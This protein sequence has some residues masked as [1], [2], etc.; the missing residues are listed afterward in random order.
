MYT[1]TKHSDELCHYGVLGMR[2]GVRR[3]QN[4]DGT[5]IGTGGEPVTNQSKKAGSSVAL[6][7][8]GKAKGNARL[9]ATAASPATKDKIKNLTEPSVKQGKGKD[10]ISPAEKI[11]RDTKKGVDASKSI[12]S[13]AEKRANKRNKDAASEQQMKKAKNMSDKELRDSINR[14]KMEREYT[15]LTTKEVESGWTKARE[16]LEVVGDVVEI[17]GA[18]LGIYLMLKKA[19]IIHSDITFEEFENTVDDD[20]IMHFVDMGNEEVEEYLEHHGVLGMK[21]GVRRYQNYD[22]TRIGAGSGSGGGGGGSSASKSFRGSVATGQGGKAVGNARFAASASIRPIPH[23]NPKNDKEKAENKAYL[24]QLSNRLESKKH[25]K[26]KTFGKEPE[27]YSFARQHEEDKLKQAVREARGLK[28]KNAA[29]QALRDHQAESRKKAD[30]YIQWEHDVRKYTGNP[31]DYM[32]LVEG[33]K[34]TK[35]WINKHSGQII[36]NDEYW[37]A[38]D[39]DILPPHVKMRRFNA[40]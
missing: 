36:T 6:G 28:D 32:P 22:G 2:W 4:Y 16:V 21:W 1:I 38:G 14:I 31:K 30:E 33:E 23:K 17:A 39:W 5:R 15:S 19:G 29:K 27:G 24:Q 26:D 8:G 18:A 7:Q 20:F 11:A 40:I 13:V 12:V 10:D 37:T 3:Y 34:F 35:E 25:R 9:A